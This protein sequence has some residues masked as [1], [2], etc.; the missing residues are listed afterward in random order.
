MTGWVL[1]YSVTQGCLLGALPCILLFVEVSNPSFKSYEHWIDCAAAVQ[2]VAAVHKL[3]DLES[4]LLFQKSTFSRLLCRSSN[5]KAITRDGAI[6][7]STNSLIRSFSKILQSFYTL[8]TRVPGESRTHTR[9]SWN[10]TSQERN[11]LHYGGRVIVIWFLK[12]NRTSD[13]QFV[14]NRCLIQKLNILTNI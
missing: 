10:F 7:I 3:L 8:Q 12:K 11:P 5:W 2:T 13:V 1:I 9:V 14:L 4:V 6:C